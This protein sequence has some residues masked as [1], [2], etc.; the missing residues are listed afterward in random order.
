METGEKVRLPPTLELVRPMNCLL[1]GVAVLV[2]AVIA[3]GNMSMAWEVIIFSFLAAVLVAAGGNAIND[4]T[5]QETDRI[6]RPNRPIPS[7]RITASRAL[8]TSQ[9][10]FIAGIALTLFLNLYC[11]LLAGLNSLVLLG[12]AWK[13]KRRGLVGNLSIGYLVG[14]TFLFGGL[15]TAHVRAGPI[16]PNEI[17]LLV[18]MASLSTVGRELIK[19]I[20]DMEGDRKL[21]FR[22]FPLIHGSGKA[23]AV[24][25]GFLGAAVAISP[26]PY[27]LGIFGWQYLVLV[28][29]SIASFLA[30][31]AMVAQSQASKAAAKASLACKVG[32]G[33]GLISFM[34]GVLV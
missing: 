19:A 31:A 22:T 18:L 9:V 10:L 7:G 8:I 32:M 23:V 4:Y 6:N 11:L 1:T 16:I 33:L 12:Y 20:E 5:D 17:L 26:L 21:G 34:V 13:L 3:V 29:G 15:A 14:S 2:G 27:V 28:I 25:V 24:A 30:A